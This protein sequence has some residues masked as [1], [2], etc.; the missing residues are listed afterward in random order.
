M[1]HYIVGWEGTNWLAALMWGVV[2]LNVHVYTRV[3][4]RGMRGRR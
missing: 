1:N 3:R 2:W 4:S